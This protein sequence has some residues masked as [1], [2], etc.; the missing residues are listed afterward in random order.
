M[1]SSIVPAPT[2]AA[3]PNSTASPLRISLGPQSSPAARSPLVLALNGGEA[4]HSA[5]RPA[6]EH[7]LATEQ[8]QANYAQT[9]LSFEPNVGQA[10][11]QPIGNAFLARTA[12]FEFTFEPD[13]EMLAQPLA[14]GGRDQNLNFSGTP[15]HM[16]LAGANRTPQSVMAEE[17][18]GK[19]NFFPASDPRT[20]RTNIPTFARVGYRDVYPGVDLFYYGNQRRLEYD[21][22]VSAGAD[23]GRI[24][25]RFA[26]AENIRTDSSG[27][28]VIASE[29]REI[30]LLRPVI[31]QPA[32]SG[33]SR[34]EVTGSYLLARE[35]AESRIGFELGDYD[36][37]RPLIIDPVLSYSAFFDFGQTFSSLGGMAVD[38]L[39]SAYLTGVSSGGLGIFIEKLSPSGSQVLY[40]TTIGNTISGAVPN[41]IAVDSTGRAYIT[42]LAP[43]NYPTTANAFQQNVTANNHAFVTVV[44]AAGNLFYSSYLAGS[45]F[46]EGLAIAVDSSMDV[47]VTGFTD[48]ADFPTTS[49]VF[50][51]TNPTGTSS[52]SG[53]VSKFNPSLSGVPSLVYS[54]YL[55]GNNFTT[56]NGIAV[57]GA[58]HA[59]VVTQNAD[60][61][62]PTTPGAFTT[63]DLS[64][65]GGVFVTELD[66]S[67]ATLV[68]SAYIGVGRGNGIAVDGGGNAYITG[69]TSAPDFPT[70][71]G[72]YQSAFP[73]GFITKL[74]ST[75]T[76]LVYSTFI[77]TFDSSTTATSIAITPGCAA[78]CNAFV[79][80]TTPATNLPVSNPIQSFNAGS[81][82]DYVLELSSDGSSAVYSTYLGGTSD[83]FS[84]FNNLLPGIAVDPNGNAYI[85]GATDS[86]DFPVTINNPVAFNFIAK[87][88][89]SNA[90]MV[91]PIPLSLGFQ[92]QI[93]TTTSSPLAVTLRNMGSAAISITN[94]ATAGDFAESNTCAGSIAGGG[95]CTVNVT[96]S[97][98]V[99]G[100]RNGTVTITHNGVNSPTVINLTG[101][102]FDGPIGTFTPANLLFNL[103]TVGTTSAA[104]PVTL[105]NT[106][107]QPLTLSSIFFFNTQG[108][109]FAQT[110]TCPGTLAPK[111]N[112][113]FNLTFAPQSAGS[114]FGTMELVTTAT[115]FPLLSLSGF[116]GG[117]GSATIAL[118]TNSIAFPPTPLN[119]PVT[120]TSVTVTNTGNV[121]VEFTS[122]TTTGDYS[123]LDNSCLVPGV[124]FLELPV[125]SSCFL[126]ATFTPTALG[127]R[128]GSL[129]LTD[130]ATGSPHVVN[131][132]GQGVNAALGLSIIPAVLSFP[133]TAV[134]SATSIQQITLLNNGNETINLDRI[135]DTGDF[136][137]S[138][139][140]CFGSLQPFGSCLLFVFFQPTAAGSRSGSVVISDSAPGSPQTVALQGN[141]LSVVSNLI[142]DPPS[143]TF[144]DT[145]QGTSASSSPLI[146]IT[147][148]GN[149]AVVLSNF[150]VSG[151]FSLNSSCVGSLAPLSSPC[152]FSVNFTPT[153]PGMRTGAVTFTATP[154]GTQTINLSG[155]GLAD[156]PTLQ[157]SPASVS[158]PDQGTGT[159]SFSQP[160]AITN[161]GNVDVTITAVSTTGDFGLVG[162]NPC[163]GF[164]LPVGSGCTI[165]VTFTPSAIG[166]RSGSLNV[167]DTASANPQTVPLSGN[168]LTAQALVFT[169]SSLAFP[170]QAVNSG[171][172]N[173]QAVLVT[174][175]GGVNVTM[176]AIAASASTSDFTV[177]PSDC[178]NRVL[179]PS[180]GN[181]TLFVQFS[182]T[183]GTGPLSGNLLINDD[184]PPGQ[185][186]VPM[187]GNSLVNSQSLVISPLSFTFPDQA[188][189]VQ[190]QTAANFHVLNNGDAPITFSNVAMAGANAGDFAVSGCIPSLPA[191]GSCTVSV[192][193]MPTAPGTRTATVQLTDSVSGTPQTIPVSGN[194]LADAPALTFVPASLAFAP[195]AVGLTSNAQTL[196]LSNTGNSP[197]SISSITLSGTNA[198]DFTLGNNCVG[199]IFA[200][201]ACFLFPTIKP[202]LT[203]AESATITITDNTPGSPHMITLS[204][205]GLSNT[206]SLVLSPGSLNFGPVQV[207]QTS[208]FSTAVYLQN[209]SAAPVNLSSISASGD[210]NIVSNGC[211]NPGALQP[212]RSCPVFMTFKATATGTRSGT[213]TVNDDAPGNPHTASLTGTG[214]SGVPSVVF[215]QNGFSFAPAVVS[216]S[217]NQQSQGFTL[218]N[219]GASPVTGVTLGIAPTTDFTL[220]ANNCTGTLNPSGGCGFTVQYVPST[221]GVR[222]ATVTATDS[223]S[224]SPQSMTVAGLGIAAVNQATV[225]TP[226][227]R[228][229][230]QA[231]GA[232]SGIQQA[233]LLNTGNVNLTIS[234]VTITQPSTDFGTTMCSTPVGPG[235][236]CIVNVTFTPTATGARGGT[237]VFNTSAGTQNVALSGTGVTSTQALVLSGSSLVFPDQA[238]GTSSNLSQ[239]LTVFNTGNSPVNITG[240]SFSDSTDFGFS[241]N[242]GASFT[243]PAGGSCAFT[244]TFMPQSVGSLSG[245]LAI[246]NSAGGPLTATVSGKGLTATQN[247]EV[248]TTNLSFPATVTGGFGNQQSI[249]L[250]NTGNSPVTVSS[251]TSNSGDYTVQNFCSTVAAHSPCGLFVTFNPTTTGNRPG[252][253]TISNSAGPNLTV[254][255]SGT[256]VSPTQTAELSA[257]SLSFGAQAKGTTSPT[258]KVTITNTGNSVLNISSIVASGDFAVQNFCTAISPQA[259][260]CGFSVSFTPTAVGNRT[261]TVTITDNATNSPQTISLSGTGVAA[262]PTL[263]FSTT[264]MKF[265]DTP[266][267]LQSFLNPTQQLTVSNTG[268]VPVTISAENLTGDY[269]FTFGGPSCTF[270]LPPNSSCPEEITFSPT[271]IGARPGT[272]MFT[273]TASG[274][275]QTINLT[276]N[277]LTPSST[278]VVSPP[279]PNFGN[280]AVNFPGMNQT[281]M[282]YNVGNTQLSINNATTSGDFT[283]PFGN[284]FCSLAPLGS[285][286]PI[287]VGFTPTA[288]GN[289]T[290]TL[291]LTDQNNVNHVINLSGTGVT[292]APAINVNPLNLGFGSQVVGAPGSF[293]QVNL[294]NT[295]NTPI[296]TGT[297]SVTGDFSA[298]PSCP[299]SLLPGSQCFVFLNFKATTSGPRTG[300]LTI[301][302]SA[303]GAPHTVSLNGTGIDPTQTISLSQTS[304]TFPSQGMGVASQAALVF[305]TNNNPSVFAT[306][307]NVSVTGDFA[308]TN[309]CGSGVFVFCTFSITFTPSATGARSGNIAITDGLNVTRNIALSG[310]GVP[311]APAV[312]FFPSQLVFGSQAVGISSLAQQ[313]TI[314]NN[315]FAPLNV[316]NAAASGD[317]S[318]SSNAC[319]GA[320]AIGNACS[321]QITFKPTATGT[322]TGTLTLTD[323]AGN[324]PQSFNLSGTAVASAPIVSLTSSS[325]TFTSQTVGTTSPV[326]MVTLNNTGNAALSITSISASQSFGQTNTC[327]SSVSAG[328]NCTISVTFSP[329]AVGQVFG[330]IT[331]VDNAS[332]SPQVITLSGTGAAGAAV[333]LSPTTV[334][335]SNQV[336]NTTS[337]SQPVTVTNSGNGNLTITNITM[338]GNFAETDNCIGSAIVPN[339]SCTINVTFTPLSL[340]ALGGT[341]SI[342][343]NAPNSP[344]VVNLSGTGTQAPAVT[345]STNTLSFGPQQLGI[346]SASQQV[347]LTD[348]GSG[349]LTITS[350]ISSGDFFQNNTCGSGVAP[351]GNCA[352]NVTYVPSVLGPESGSITITDNAPGSPHVISLSGTGI[353]PTTNPVPV[354]ASFAFADNGMVL[355]TGTGF[356]PSSVA[357]W[358]GSPRTTT[359][360][361]IT[362]LQA[363]LLPGDI[364]GGT[365]TLSVFNPTP[366]GGTSN[367]LSIPIVGGSYSISDLQPAVANAGGPPLNLS[368][369]G[370]GFVSGMTVLWNGAARPTTFVNKSLLMASLTVSDMASPGV[371]QVTV[372][373]PVSGAESNALNFAVSDFEASAAP[374]NIT[375]KRGDSASITVSITPVFGTFSG[376]V[377]LSCGNLPA[378]TTCSFSPATVNPNN[379][380]VT[381]T[382]TVHASPS[383]MMKAPATF[384]S[385]GLFALWLGGLPLLG[386]VVIG[387]A[388]RR[389]RSAW[390]VI[391]L[392]TLLLLTMVACGGGSSMNSGPT[393]STPAPSA[394]SAT[395]TVDAGSGP[396]QHSATVSIVIQ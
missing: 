124:P 26:G 70:T 307:A 281:L 110:N 159:T 217:N 174:N 140:S 276:G 132:T 175:P 65:L 161:V 351:G 253:I 85:A 302:D 315:G 255:L 301:N 167:I 169:P 133:D 286:C 373:N 185:Q 36:R 362:Q 148:S 214:T 377:S 50:Q 387:A 164:F 69:I 191:F 60:F 128:S 199:T 45:S 337:A 334:V 42:G 64:N 202:S 20:W 295:G 137:L 271:G 258:Q 247:L 106:G 138:N 348:S 38:S 22:V 111:S 221:S 290:G 303:P 298:T 263:V 201:S 234:S 376:A 34:R 1:Q 371:F 248:S 291:T 354:I 130:S 177:N 211:P 232:T 163:V 208:N 292:A 29:G 52:Q 265:A 93:V 28:L 327:G 189:G 257:G 117:V 288:L 98:T 108:S 84:G 317:F 113:T 358:N 392:L 372:K 195:V 282:M 280:Q 266:T 259:S 319:T 77:G 283:L 14:R 145:P 350:I 136:H 170:D 344:Q 154:G 294:T 67:A 18:P 310:T 238:K 300:T 105:T 178:N 312:S 200:Q 209:T 61:T 242:C 23:P 146:T 126:D 267:G 46:E 194:G 187:S 68:Y 359:F 331:I 147:N 78:N 186:S 115:N 335:F 236:S 183:S 256:G 196:Q 144:P 287:T 269:T 31:Y 151:D 104:L 127:T 333:M 363:A 157:F 342:K 109:P 24:R 141:G 80:G 57:D 205:S 356:V 325:L 139:N 76:A 81:T 275:P 86:P 382:L 47:Y 75:G 323:N 165:N 389:K 240:S 395:F 225:Q 233:F 121:P 274:S 227:L 129:T 79:A 210:F 349:P 308:Q 180:G 213:L 25:L 340:G 179:L 5:A 10:P 8:L 197:V 103:Q 316:T 207:N 134:G 245:T 116:G 384:Q 309:T 162:T 223:D 270:T 99:N 142:I 95:E 250:N 30:R 72:A 386:I 119:T 241:P 249:T 91:L 289:R 172:A 48:S 381:S 284:S 96:F 123:I 66:P 193:F 321:I 6:V 114:F 318:V 122:T 326:Q 246:N 13:G 39:G 306:V 313:V 324:S 224:S 73:D 370:S 63:S 338:T 380:V 230:N 19:A 160:V 332:G 383:A 219:N 192:T 261:G 226:S 339:A 206:E 353:N 368:V 296:N 56:L 168:G 278:I 120:S 365:N 305:Y 166:L 378:G 7:K 149:S 394:V 40:T 12:D 118:S 11:G 89:P 299:A 9:P 390:L 92:N 235:G 357:Q 90:G 101:L 355:I 352:I 190:S 173:Q 320:V 231:V 322:R 203:S 135:Q 218:I 150:A 388:P 343:D 239:N 33:H 244:F 54:T 156:N 41:A 94:V 268:N 347:T 74:N 285:G 215:S 4:A 262:T 152:E 158:F 260:N 182:P 379:R 97:P 55:G 254:T 82:D 176:G 297:I 51:T 304:V 35:G 155:N 87:I 252:M 181:C 32:E 237:L 369:Q 366:G 374:A 204:G 59:F 264:S 367:I 62:Y 102:G 393:S 107:D 277:G 279:A 143:V 188:V 153:A 330:S 229:G 17:L 16:W 328:A 341:I 37:S 27:D 125:G 375:V 112:C 272:L 360:I 361:S 329:T 2:P 83:E 3:S 293:G 44:D 88:S 364:S 53:F 184:V 222:T 336:I 346:A 100:T 243:L 251:V 21:F 228:F 15:I 385:R 396:L 212:N 49:G 220:T 198:A 131:L 311:A 43:A 391:G 273:D 58:G 345:L 71:P 216:A 314:T 171:P